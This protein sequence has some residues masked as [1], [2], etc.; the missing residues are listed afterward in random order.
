MTFLIALAVVTVSGFVALSY[1][2]LWYRVYSF[3][4]G[5]TAATF[6]LLLG[7]YLFGLA[8]GA[9]G[10]RLRCGD[11]NPV[12]NRSKLKTVGFLMLGASLA[13]FAVI[14]LVGWTVQRATFAWT[15]PAVAVAAGLMG[16]ILPL[17]AH[18]SIPPDA[19]AGRR[20][21]YLYVAN[22]VGSASGSLLTG[23]VFLDVLSLEQTAL[24]I[25]LLSVAVTVPFFWIG[26]SSRVGR[27][28]SLGVCAL[29]AVLLVVSGPFAFD[30]LFEKLIL[31][32]NYRPG[33][34]FSFLVQNRS[35]VIG[36]AG[37]GRVYGGGVYDGMFSLDPVANENGILRAYSLSGLHPEPRDVLMVGLASGSWA[38]VIAHSE[39]VER[40][41]I[42]EINPGYLELI[43]QFHMVASL[44]THPKV[45][46]IVD[47]GRRWLTAHPDRQFDAIVMNT[48][49]HWRGQATNLLSADFLSRAKSHLRPG[50][51]MFFNATDFPAVD[52]TA[53]TVFR[54]G[55]HLFNHMAV[56]DEPFDFDPQR[57][58]ADLRTYRVDG[59]P[60]LPDDPTKWAVVQ[61][62]VYELLDPARG[63]ASCAQIRERYEEIPLITQDN[64]L[65]EWYRSPIAVP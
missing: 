55:Y 38:Q 51:V 63:F 15:L 27:L 43:P 29:A 1:E 12:G 20:L 5:G 48:T 4:T 30:H 61:R 65:P 2:I 53:C 36:V 35:G 44:L 10:S 42:V 25:A 52:K 47:D 18:F 50:G 46:V 60:V 34:A 59:E 62:H 3:V 64:M 8:L 40:L 16:A 6:G 32:D 58:L 7:A 14:P 19:H 28:R 26:S 54:Y 21:S 22:I 13:G 41:T 39:R 57:V 37:D 49:F 56:S 31:K 45:E 24:L 17:I 9:Y 11:G 23:F 33:A